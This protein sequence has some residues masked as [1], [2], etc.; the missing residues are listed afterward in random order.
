MPNR[1]KRVCFFVVPS[2]DVLDLAGPWSVFG[3]A[4]DVLGRQAYELSVR[5]PLSGRVRTRH[6]LLVGDVGGLPRGN[7][8][9]PDVAVVAGGSP[10]DPPPLPVLRLS[11]WLKQRA[12]RI[13]TLVSICTGA[14][15]L[16]AAGLL[17]GKKVT[18]H[19]RFLAELQRRFPR[20]RVVDDGIFVR[21]GRLWTSAG[22]SAGVDL[23]LG[24]VESDHG[25]E[26][27][28]SV[29][30]SLVLFLRRS[31]NQ[32]QFS[33]VLE[34]QTKEP[35]KLRDIG[36]FVLEHLHEELSVEHLARGVGT[37]PRSLTRWCRDH[38]DEAPA[39]LV[40][41]IR[42]E[43]VRRLLEETSLPLKDLASRTG[44]GDPSTLWRIFTQRMGVTPAAYRARFS[45]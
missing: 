38:L 10:L 31:G 22:I 35:A 1:T 14:F 23:S 37:S 30:R 17:D 44:M 7:A 41:R 8:R 16:G 43:Q 39:E 9:L 25:R 26:V 19:W 42:L 2:S 12:A 21:Q 13:P 24:L 45:R 15:V 6:G 32:A 20:A 33:A 5:G 29:A 3:H 18:T 27:A 11:R 34:R 40:R 28:M 4:N 36:A